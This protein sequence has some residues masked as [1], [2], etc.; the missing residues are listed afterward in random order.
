MNE[1]S[2]AVGRLPD[3]QLTQVRTIS[4]VSQIQKCTPVLIPQEA[5]RQDIWDLVLSIIIPSKML[6]S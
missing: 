5:E 6:T 4:G 2:Y 1:H 3:N